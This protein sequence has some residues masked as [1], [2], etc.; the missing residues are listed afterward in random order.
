MEDIEFSKLVLKPI[1]RARNTAVTAPTSRAAAITYST[2]VKPFCFAKN[3]LQPELL[4]VFI[5][6]PTVQVLTV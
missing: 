2:T 4:N 6:P 3:L 5:A 1:S